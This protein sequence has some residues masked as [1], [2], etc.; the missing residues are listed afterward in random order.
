MLALNSE[1][2]PCI[3]VVNRHFTES[4][5]NEPKENVDR[6][7]QHSSIHFKINA[8]GVDR[9]CSI[10]TFTIYSSDTV[11]PP[12]P[13]YLS[14]VK[15]S[16]T[17]EALSTSRQVDM[18]TKNTDYTFIFD[19][20]C[21]LETNIEYEFVWHTN[22]DDTSTRVNTAILVSK[23]YGTQQDIYYDGVPNLRPICLVKFIYTDTW[24]A[25][26]DYVNDRIIESGGGQGTVQS[27]NSKTPVD[28]NVV[29]EASDIDYDEQ[30]TVKQ[31]IDN[32]ADKSEVV[33]SV[34][35][36]EDILDSSWNIS[37]STLESDGITY[38]FS[39][40]I[41]KENNDSIKAFPQYKNGDT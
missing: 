39:L 34:D 12:G 19:N 1:V 29:L 3:D 25:S 38:E 31:A 41:Q 28:G 37:P 4:T 26:I 10:Q 40:A 30:Q 6:V 11:N 15:S 16:N 9:P 7:S 36:N 23:N 27:V 14:I 24:L 35:F 13:V 20:I 17:S 2:Q 8:F 32:K 18:S 22:K 21:K 5:W 33:L